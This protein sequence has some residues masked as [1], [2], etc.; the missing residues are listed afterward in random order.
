MLGMQDSKKSY[1]AEFQAIMIRT[2]S[3]SGLAIQ[4]T[5]GNLTRGSDG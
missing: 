3:I 5:T 2:M 4:I 1:A